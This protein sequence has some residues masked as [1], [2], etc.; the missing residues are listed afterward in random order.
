[1]T[2]RF[3]LGVGLILAIGAF[4]AD[5]LSK[6]WA[7]DLFPD[8]MLS[9][10]EITPF[11]NLVMAHN[12]GVA[13]SLFANDHDYGPVLLAGSAIAVVL[14]FVH[15]LTRAENKIVVYGIGLV[16]GGALGNAYDRLVYGAVI[17]FLDVHA[18][19]Y[20][21]PAFN[22]ADSCVVCGVGLLLIDSFTNAKK[23]SK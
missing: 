3:R 21:W 22:I 5:R 1:M 20:H 11:F 19:G 2:L 8:G 17:D 18:M 13:F 16:I 14:F 7:L 15:W 12:T 6:N 9:P 10:I 23:K 4:V